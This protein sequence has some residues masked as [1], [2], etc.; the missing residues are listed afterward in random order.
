MANRIVY[1]ISDTRELRA[2]A[3]EGCWS[4]AFRRNLKTASRRD[5]NVVF[6]NLVV[7]DENV[8]SKESAVV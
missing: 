6:G 4:P 3:R 7:R 1:N 5:S 8:P 2:K